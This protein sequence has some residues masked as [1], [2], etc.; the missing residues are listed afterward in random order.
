MGGPPTKPTTYSSI[1]HTTN[2]E[3]A[4][5][6]QQGLIVISNKH[7]S[8][9]ILVKLGAVAADPAA[10]DDWH[11]FVPAGMTR[12]IHMGQSQLS[13]YHAGASTL[14]Y[15]TDFTVLGWR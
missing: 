7:A 4:W 1:G 10:A 13:L 12:E 6:N 15:D 3:F 5:P 9:T 8:E 11:L 14:T 2:A